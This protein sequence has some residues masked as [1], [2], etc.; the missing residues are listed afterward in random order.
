MSS[1][2]LAITVILISAVAVAYL[3]SKM[4]RAN[5]IRVFDLICTHSESD[6]VQMYLEDERVVAENSGF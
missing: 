6:C 1:R 2:N 3:M 5:A 4:H